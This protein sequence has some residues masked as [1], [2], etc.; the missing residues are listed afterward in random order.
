MH[1]TVIVEVLK[2]SEFTFD[3][4]CSQFASKFRF[5]DCFLISWKL[6]F[7]TDIEIGIKV[8]T[9]QIE[10]YGFSIIKEF[11]ADCRP[12]MIER[13]AHVSSGE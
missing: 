6:T 11:E 8:Q 9:N 5:A 4:L 12:G 2:M 3:L 13:N 10:I 7:I 1:L